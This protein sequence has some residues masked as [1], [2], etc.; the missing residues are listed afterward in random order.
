MDKGREW[1]SERL[2]FQD[3]ITGI[4]VTRWT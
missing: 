3:P 2:N 1:P 4:N